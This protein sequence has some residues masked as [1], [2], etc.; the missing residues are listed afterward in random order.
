MGVYEQ[1]GVYPVQI[2]V[3]GTLGIERV[4]RGAIIIRYLHRL[5]PWLVRRSTGSDWRPARTYEYDFTMTAQATIVAKDKAER[6]ALTS[7]PESDQTMRAAFSSAS[8]H[9]C[10]AQYATDSGERW[11]RGCGQIT[12]KNLP[13]AVAFTVAVE[14]PDGRRIE[15][16]TVGS[17]GFSARAGDSGIFTVYPSEFIRWEQPG[18][19]DATVVLT[20]A[21]D[22]AYQDPAIKTLWDGTLR[23]PISFK[24]DANPPRGWPPQP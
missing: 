11:I 5:F 12:Y 20:P 22:R 21:P 18:G 10:V 2:R 8:S 4:D 1:P 6:V 13:T 15:E 19:Y 7:S 9:N 16:T 24:I 17:R 3:Q 23:F 14:L